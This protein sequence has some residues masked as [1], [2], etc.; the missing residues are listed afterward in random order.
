MYQPQIINQTQD[1]S[2]ARVQL[3]AP[4][5][6]AY[7]DVH[8]PSWP[9]LPGVVQLHWAIDLTRR[10]FGEVGEFGGIENLKFHY[11]IAPE[12][13]LCLTLEYQPQTNRVTFTY[14]DE[15]RSYSSGRISFRAS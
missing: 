8:F 2:I 5:A 13:E 1:G 3:R 4:R 15:R 9:I 10:L 7:F 11:V 6:L 12:S 14:G